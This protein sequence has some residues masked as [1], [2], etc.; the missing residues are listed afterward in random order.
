MNALRRRKINISRVFD[1]CL[2]EY[3]EDHSIVPLKKDDIKPGKRLQ[4]SGGKQNEPE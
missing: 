1:Q 3:C 2:K 4:D